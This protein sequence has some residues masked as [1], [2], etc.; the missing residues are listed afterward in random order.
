M[1]EDGKV[2]YKVVIDDNGVENEAESAGR[3]AGDGV[4]R[5]ASRG[6]SA[7]REMMIGAA[8][9]IGQ[10]FVQMAADAVRGVESIAKAGVEFNAQ[11]EQYQT[12]FTTLIGDADKA[13]SALEA[14][15]K[16][17]ASTPFDVAS[18]VQANQALLATGMDAGKARKD[19]MNLANAIAATGGGSAELSRMAANMQQIRNTGK[20]TAM[21]IR[22]FANAG[23]NIYGLLADSLGVSVEKAAEMDVTYEQLTAAFAKAAEAGGAYEGAMEAQSQTFNGRMST[24][25]DNATQLAGELTQDLFNTLSGDMLPKVMQWVEAL[26]HGAQTGGIDGAIEVAKSILTYLFDTFMLN[27]PNVL[28]MGLNLLVTLLNGITNSL[29]KV[30]ETVLKILKALVDKLVEHGPD[31]LTSGLNLV[32]K[33]GEGLVKALPDLLEMAGKLIMGLFEAFANADWTTIGANIVSGIWEGFVSLW[34]WLKE[35]MGKAMDTIWG[36]AKSILGIASPSKKFMY[37][38]EMSAKGM[39]E[40]FAEGEDEMQ[41]SVSHTTAAMVEAA[42]GVSG[43]GESMERS[44]S[45]N[46]AATTGGTTIIVPLSIDGREVARATAWSMGEQLAW[47]EM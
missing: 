15:R 38:G 44:V 39:A 37:I 41:K 36:W 33:L 21:D 7:F 34:E 13:K 30:G 43:A 42:T 24:L 10:A 28:D 20:A 22:Q 3:K 11:M 17:A 32:I 46:L 27:F 25:K 23:I 29:P 45:Y 40:G 26:L 5:G 8:R 14:I 1:G 6:T 12:A 31:L 19:V 35:Q 9:A 4:E 18:L 2:I 16:D 47:E